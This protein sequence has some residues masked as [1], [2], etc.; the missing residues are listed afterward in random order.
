M[1]DTTKKTTGAEEETATE[2][3]DTPKTYTQEE[4]EKL[5]QKEGD[6]RVTEALKKAEKKNQ[7]KVKEAQ[8]LAQMNEQEKYEYELKQR[9]KA[10]AEKEMELTLAE[11]KNE[12]SKI[13]S[14]K[15]LSLTLVDFVVADDAD[16][17]KSNIDLLDRAFKASVRAEVEKRLGSSSPKKSTAS[18]GVVTKDEFNKMTISEQAELFKTNPELYKQLTAL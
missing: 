18:D 17:M 13:L 6:R 12:A 1:E 3:N 5:L 14:E 15:G 11:N 8:K 9:E 16:T 10:I 2:N 7:D 4:V